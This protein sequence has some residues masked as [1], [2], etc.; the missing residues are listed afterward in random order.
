MSGIGWLEIF[1]KTYG[2][3]FQ[4]MSGEN[5]IVNNKIFDVWKSKFVSKGHTV[6]AEV[7]RAF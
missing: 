1:R 4:K 5:A 7:S 3:I 2:I 6:N